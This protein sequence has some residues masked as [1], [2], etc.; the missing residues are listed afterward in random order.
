MNPL[1]SPEK[2]QFPITRQYRLEVSPLLAGQSQTVAELEC[3]FVGFVSSV[4]YVPNAAL[5]GAATNNRTLSLV[6]VT[7]PVQGGVVAA[8]TLDQTV[9]VAALTPLNI[10]VA[11]PPVPVNP[12]VNNTNFI[13]LP[14]P[15]LTAAC[16]QSGDVLEL[17]N[18]AAGSGMA[19]PGG[20]LTVTVTRF[21][22]IKGV[23]NVRHRNH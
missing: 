3:P 9:N 17:Q 11:A 23:P 19:D 6:N 21:Q 7:T 20:V 15:A 18:V 5:V 1:S 12:A 13:T 14:N 22:C 4:Q 16:V 2:L 10:P 8:V